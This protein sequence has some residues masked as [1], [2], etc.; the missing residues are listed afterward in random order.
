M[1]KIA[2]LGSTGS[3]GKSTLA[4]VDAFPD[5]L[6]VCGLAAGA[7]VELLAEQVGRYRPSVVSVKSAADA[8]RLRALVSG[9]VEIIPGIEGACAVA[10]MG[11]ADTVIASLGKVS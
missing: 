1:K 9:P 4:V 8:E 10:A 6:R 7:N 11:E 3:I 5:E 2:I